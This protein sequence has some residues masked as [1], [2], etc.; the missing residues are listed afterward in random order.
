MKTRIIGSAIGLS[1]L[2]LAASSASGAIVTTTGNGLQIPAPASCVPGAL[3][4][5][6]IAHA[7]DELQGVSLSN[8]LV[9]MVNNPGASSSPLAGTVSGVVDSHIVHVEDYSGLPPAVGTIV[10]NNPI[11]GVIM[12]NNTLDN[13]DFLGAG[14]TT[15]PTFYPFRDLTTNNSSFSINA[16]VLSFNLTN[17]SPVFGVVQVRVLTQVPAPGVVSVAGLAGLAVIR[18][19]RTA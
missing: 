13:T 2:V 4:G 3:T 9:D 5:G 7:W 16:N 11:V 15:Y 6:Q 12:F 17:L 19:R 18:R 1:T 14:G 10:F 8:L